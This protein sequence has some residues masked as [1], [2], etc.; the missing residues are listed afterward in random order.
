M[1]ILSGINLT[2]WMLHIRRENRKR[3]AAFQASGMTEEERTYQNKIA[4][5]L[6]LTDI[7]G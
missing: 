1:L 7:R 6:D 2:L 4:G 3:D 5:E